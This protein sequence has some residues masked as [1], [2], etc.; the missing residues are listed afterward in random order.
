[1]ADKVLAIIRETLLHEN[2]VE[3]LTFSPATGEVV[4]SLLQPNDRRVALVT[5][6]GCHWS[7]DLAAGGRGS[8]ATRFRLRNPCPPGPAARIEDNPWAGQIA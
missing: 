5:V 1:M 4:L 6:P 7:P 2:T 8:G 3:G